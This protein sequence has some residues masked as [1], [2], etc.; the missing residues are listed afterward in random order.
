MFIR[1]NILYFFVK[2]LSNEGMASSSIM[3]GLGWI[4]GKTS[5]KDWSGTRIGCPGRWWSHRPRR[6]SR[7]VWMWY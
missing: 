2:N 4:L 7:S 6:C 3:R 5:S 1:E